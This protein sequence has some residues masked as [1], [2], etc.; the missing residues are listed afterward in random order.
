MLESDTPPTDPI[1]A[2]ITAAG[3]EARVVLLAS[4]LT[5]LR[6]V[7]Q[8]LDH[9]GIS[10]TALRWSM[11]SGADRSAFHTFTEHTGARHLPQCYLDGQHVGGTLELYKALGLTTPVGSGSG[12]RLIGMARVLGYAGL[13]PFLVGGLLVMLWGHGPLGGLDPVLWVCGY[14]AVILSFI[15]AVHWGVA[16]AGPVGPIKAHVM[17]GLSV[18]P[19]LIAWVALLILPQSAAAVLLLCVSFMGWWFYERLVPGKHVLAR[20]YVRLRLQLSTV[21]ALTLFVVWLRLVAVG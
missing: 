15:G 19:A 11:A 12:E 8:R 1:T 6:E 17:L 16:L 10:H 13:I 4:S 3:R 21:A 7:E 9:A 2:Q 18:V 5:D 14:A 20:W